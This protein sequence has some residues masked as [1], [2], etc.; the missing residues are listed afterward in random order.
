MRLELMKSGFA[1]RRLAN[2]ATRALNGTSPKS[3]VGNP[4]SSD[5]LKSFRLEYLRGSS[6]SLGSNL[7]PANLKLETRIPDF[8]HWTW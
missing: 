4:V 3:K 5:G 2:L 6:S 8:G 7:K 1:I